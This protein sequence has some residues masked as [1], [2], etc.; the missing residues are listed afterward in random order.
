MSVIKEIVTHN[1]LAKLDVLLWNCMKE[2]SW[3]INSF[4]KVMGLIG[5][6]MSYH[7]NHM[8]KRFLLMEKILLRWT[9]PVIKVA[10]GKNL[11]KVAR[12]V[13]MIIAYRIGLGINR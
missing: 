13:L 12:V 3:L 4:V 1:Q 7:S 8:M 11:I 5:E 9:K 6:Y 10:F 2:K